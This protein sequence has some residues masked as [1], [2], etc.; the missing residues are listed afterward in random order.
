MYVWRKLLQNLIRCNLRICSLLEG[1]RRESCGWLGHVSQYYVGVLK[2][3][4]T[5]ILFVQSILLCLIMLHY[6]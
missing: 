4:N 6:L 2:V 3:Y 5:I 1:G